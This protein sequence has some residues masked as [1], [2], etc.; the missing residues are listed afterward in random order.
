MLQLQYFHR[1]NKSFF[2]Q[3]QYLRPF[4]MHPFELCTIFS[5][6]MMLSIVDQGASQVHSGKGTIYSIRSEYFIPF[7]RCN[8]MK[9]CIDHISSL[10]RSVLKY[11]QT[12]LTSLTTRIN[13]EQ[14]VPRQWI[15]E[16]ANMASH[17]YLFSNYTMRQIQMVFL[18]WRPAARAEVVIMMRILMK[19]Y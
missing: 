10:S 2:L 11:Q 4:T 15:S 5:I 19:A 6:L 3:I 17:Y 16:I 14:R 18:Y 1:F 8:Y 7:W 9:I 13:M 12:A